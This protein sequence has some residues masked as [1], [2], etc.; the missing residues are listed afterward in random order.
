[1]L[2]LLTLEL[3]RSYASTAGFL[4]FFRLD[5]CENVVASIDY[6]LALSLSLKFDFLITPFSSFLPGWLISRIGLKKRSIIR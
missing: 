5:A 6:F 1:M 4:P 2:L 3:C